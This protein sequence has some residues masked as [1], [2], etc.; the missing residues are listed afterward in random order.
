VEPLLPR[1]L[2]R[3]ERHLGSLQAEGIRQ[4]V[5]AGPIRRALHRRRGETHGQ[6]R[7]RLGHGVLP[8][9]L[10]HSLSPAD[11]LVSGGARLDV[12]PQLDAQTFPLLA[13]TRSRT[14]DTIIGVIEAAKEQVRVY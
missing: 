5:A 8:P 13:L 2:P 6:D 4:K 14:F 1:P 7:Q 9:T 3:D 11:D 12:D 10:L